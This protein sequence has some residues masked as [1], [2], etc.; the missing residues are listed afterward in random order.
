[1][2]NYVIIGNGVAAAG[3]VEGI[4]SQDAEGGIT[5]VSQEN[6]PVY[7]RPL[8]SYYLE[9]KAAV[10]RMNYR[11]ADFYVQN[12]CQV[13]YGKTALALDPAARQV[14]LDGGAALSYDR[15]CIAAGSSPFV[16]PFAGLSTVDKQ[17]TFM[18]LDD[19]LALNQ[20][21]DRQSRVLIIGGGLIG[22][23]CAEGLQGRAGQIT[24]CDLADHL[25]SSILDSA[26]AQVLQ[27]AL[28]KNGVRF[29]LGTSVAQF[30]GHTAVLSD[31]QQLDF[32]VLVLA[33]GVRPNTALVKDAG[34]QVNRGIVIDAHMQTSLPEIYAAGDCAEGYDCSL[35]EN[36]VL[37]ILPNAYLQGYCA[38]VNMAGGSQ[39]FANAIPMNA[40]GFYGVHALTAGTYVSPEQGGQ[41]YEETGPGKIKRLYT[42][43]N[44]LTGFIL[45]GDV[46][47]AGIYTALIRNQTPLDAVD[48]PRLQISP[49]LA[50]FDQNTRRKTLGGVV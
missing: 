19:A 44:R 4:R 39:E 50:A 49:D 35:G 33:V 1:M 10:E 26:C 28:E 43:D 12:R 45:I 41:C 23:K 48:F 36:R 30:S 21:V 6:R 5:I 31:G 24:V 32:D 20:A 18:T 34:G 25:L 47:R 7:C 46:D 15:L 8:I 3:C 14:T 27:Q 11:P 16:P 38:G 22:L 42:K 9:G 13:H 2:K 29:L 37:A 40:I 17:F